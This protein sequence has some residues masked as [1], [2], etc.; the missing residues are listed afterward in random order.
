MYKEVEYYAKLLRLQMLTE[1][2]IEKKFSELVHPS[3]Y[4]HFKCIGYM[5]VDI[6]DL[7]I[8]VVNDARENSEL[9]FPIFAGSVETQFYDPADVTVDPISG[10]IG[11]IDGM[12][13]ERNVI[14]GITN[15][16]NVKPDDIYSDIIPAPDA[17]N[18]FYVQI[19][20]TDEHPLDFKEPPLIT[21]DSKSTR[22]ENFENF[23]KA[24][25]NTGVRGFF[26]PNGKFGR[27]TF[28]YLNNLE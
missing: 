1:E 18:S 6:S 7:N 12:Y 8:W 14:V 24:Y 28:L 16:V 17:P 3:K 15:A 19:R 11:K 20:V 23:K 10:K 5:I 22:C 13:S 27:D 25:L 4:F 26:S 2:E 9:Y 21:V